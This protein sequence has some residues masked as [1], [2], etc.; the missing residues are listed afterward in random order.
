[1][2][3]ITIIKIRFVFIFL[4][5]LL[6][7][8]YSDNL[9]LSYKI[10]SKNIFELDSYYIIEQIKFLKSSENPFDYLLGKFDG[11]NY[12]TFLDALP[13]DMIKKNN[14]SDS[15]NNELTI[16]IEA[17]NSYEYIRYSII[18]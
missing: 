7:I 16:D 9:D 10:I 13:I 15:S 8:T 12:S 1:M 18:N 17:P 4:P 14:V 3:I 6:D 5:F 2:S 11:S